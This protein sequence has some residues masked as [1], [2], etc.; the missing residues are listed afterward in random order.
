MSE[1]EAHQPIEE[2]ERSVRELV[3]QDPVIA[4]LWEQARRAGFEVELVLRW[5]RATK[6]MAERRQ[7]LQAEPAFQLDSAD[8]A[9]LRALGIDGTRRAPRPRRKGEPLHARRSDSSQIRDRL[10]PDESP[11]RR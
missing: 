4:V 11:S 6:M 1:P 7:P 9:L 8:V 10:R 2:L 5:R 3:D